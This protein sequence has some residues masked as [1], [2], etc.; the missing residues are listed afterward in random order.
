MPAF[1]FFFCTTH[2]I[3][4]LTGTEIFTNTT[5]RKNL[6]ANVWV[7]ISHKLF[8]FISQITFKKKKQQQHTYYISKYT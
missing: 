5:N 3:I 2:G 6:F 8:N 1:F 4:I 7:G